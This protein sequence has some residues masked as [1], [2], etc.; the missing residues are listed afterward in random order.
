MILTFG[1][2]SLARFSH[3]IYL[4]IYSYIYLFSL[5]LQARVN[6]AGLRFYKM[7]LYTVIIL[8]T[9]LYTAQLDTP[10]FHTR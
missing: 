3:D 5:I 7:Q 4:F 9:Q 1:P 6:L 8:Y 10:Q 2:I